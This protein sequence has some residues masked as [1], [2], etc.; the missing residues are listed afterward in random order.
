MSIFVDT[1]IL[2]R[3]VDAAD[4][5]HQLV[6][7]AIRRL[8]EAG[9]QLVI[10][11]QV[12]AEYL[13]VATR[14][15]GVNGLGQSASAAFQQVDE[16]VK[17]FELHRPGIDEYDH[18]RSLYLELLPSGKKVHDLKHVAAMKSLGVAHLLTLNA[19]DFRKAEAVGHIRII[20]PQDVVQ[21]DEWR[22]LGR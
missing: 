20:T 5:L 3:F 8:Q 11:P 21:N 4:P 15:V 9:D 17:V 12:V 18:F 7:Q 6:R 13:S 2:G 14:P 16:M 22:L 10:T 19:P 1:C